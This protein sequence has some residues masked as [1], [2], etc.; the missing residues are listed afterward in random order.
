M[1]YY[2]SKGNICNFYLDKSV[3]HGECAHI[4]RIS[5]YLAFKKYYAYLSGKCRITEDIF[6]ALK[7]LKHGNLVNLEEYFYENIDSDL[8]DAYTYDYIESEDVNILEMD[9]DFT[10]FNLEQLE[11]L[12]ELFTS[13]NI[14]TKDVKAANSVMTSDKIILIDPDC[15][16]FYLS[17]D[18]EQLR[19]INRRELLDLFITLYSKKISV[20][21]NVYDL[22][23]VVKAKMM[24]LD[25]F[26]KN[27]VSNKSVTDEVSKKLKYY[28]RPIDYFKK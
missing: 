19:S 28:K 22:R 17:S 2:D 9:K 14:K 23:D 4:Y 24:V 8:I 1:Q 25:L 5:G 26:D 27:L 6:K 20:C 12:F 3:H 16:S 18:K 15:F 13:L 7:S 11:E 21:N 10:L